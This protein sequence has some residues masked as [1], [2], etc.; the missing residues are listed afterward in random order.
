MRLKDFIYG[1]LPYLLLAG[2]ALGLL[3]AQREIGFSLNKGF[4]AGDRGIMIGL[5]EQRALA[6]AALLFAAWKILM[7]RRR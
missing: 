2:L 7:R 6:L 4:S 3:F 1:N 5:A